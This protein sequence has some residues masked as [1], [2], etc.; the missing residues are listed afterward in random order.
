[1]VSLVPI[2]VDSLLKLPGLDEIS[3]LLGGEAGGCHKLLCHR[4]SRFGGSA[5]GPSEN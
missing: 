1:M 2:S 4:H 3:F 5:P